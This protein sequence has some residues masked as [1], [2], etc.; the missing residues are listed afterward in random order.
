MAIDRATIDSYQDQKKDLVLF[1]STASAS[2][3]P[4]FVANPNRLCVVCEVGLGSSDRVAVEY[5]FES[6]HLQR[7]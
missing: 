1:P 7:H 6:S 4:K 2:S 3:G 5:P